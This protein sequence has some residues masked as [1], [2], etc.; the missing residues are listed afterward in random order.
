LIVE[1]SVLVS[2]IFLS[3]Q[4]SMSV[5]TY[6]EKHRRYTQC[7]DPQLILKDMIGNRSG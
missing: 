6:K 1:L 3:T 2:K 5:G 7:V 4:S